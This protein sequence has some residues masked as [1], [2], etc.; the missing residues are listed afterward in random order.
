MRTPL[1]SNRNLVG[2]VIFMKYTATCG[3]R[4]PVFKGFREDKHPSDCLVQLN[5][6][7]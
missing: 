1:G 4:K 5:I 7:K 3:L 6:S 2:T